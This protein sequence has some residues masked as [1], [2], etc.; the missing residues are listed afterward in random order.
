MTTYL[1]FIARAERRS[2]MC[3]ESWERLSVCVP[4]LVSEHVIYSMSLRRHIKSSGLP[5]S[6]YLLKVKS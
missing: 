2:M 3:R 1:H 4:R 5:D 6:N